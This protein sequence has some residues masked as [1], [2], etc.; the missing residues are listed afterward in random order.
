MM[1]I[2]V[3]CI[4]KLKA[5]FLKDGVQEY[6]KR[7]TSYASVSILE[8]NE[9]RVGD[10][11][12]DA[13]RRLAVEAEG[14]RLLT[15]IKSEQFVFLLDVHGSTM[16]SEQLSEKLEELGVAGRSDVVFVIGGA[17]GVSQS[18]RERADVKLSF[19]KM[20]YTHQ[21]I[22]MLLTEQIYRAFKIMKNEPYH[23]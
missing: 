11:P 23:W 9:E 8:L 10:K 17:F 4:G 3:L 7:L 15:R 5:S 13:D 16:S 19:G 6:L 22:R 20:T 2:T 1:K 21:M 18:L 14:E 12:N